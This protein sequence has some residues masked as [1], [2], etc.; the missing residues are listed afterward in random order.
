M[1]SKSYPEHRPFLRP[2][3]ECRF[4]SLESIRKS[5]ISSANRPSRTVLEKSGASRV[6]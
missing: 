6:S 3:S 4:S 1:H 5:L 2:L